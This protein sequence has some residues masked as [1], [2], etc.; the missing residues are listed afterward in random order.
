[1]LPPGEKE[2]KKRR[3]KKRKENRL[4]MDLEYGDYD[5]YSSDNE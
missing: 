5:L 2:K 3:E 4:R 1:M